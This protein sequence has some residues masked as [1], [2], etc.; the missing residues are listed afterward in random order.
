MQRKL[1]RPGGGGV[2]V[3]PRRGWTHAQL[4]I[5]TP[6]ALSRPAHS[7]RQLMNF[8]VLGNDDRGG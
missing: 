3:A 5:T 4:S 8:L 7:R 2:C 1:R 6:R